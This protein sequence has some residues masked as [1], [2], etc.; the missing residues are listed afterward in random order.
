M[1][2]RRAAVEDA[3]ALSAL[4]A[5]YLREKYPSHRGTSADELRRDVLSDTG[6]HRVL[7]ADGRGGRVGFVSWDPVYDMHWAARGAQ[8]ADLY[9]V[10]SARGLGIAIALLAGVC[11][12]ASAEGATFLRGGSYDR[13]SPTGRFYER[14]AIGVDS[15]ECHCS[16]KAFRRLADLHGNPIRTIIRSLPPQEWNFQT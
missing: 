2:V 5:D 7:L 14:F 3:W 9:V 4:L 13:A 11:A 6:G 16:G 10:P 1:T 15:A 8:V 12:E